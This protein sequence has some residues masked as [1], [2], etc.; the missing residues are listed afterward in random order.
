MANST[1][2]D[3]DISA[4]VNLAAAKL[5]YPVVQN[6]HCAVLKAF[7]KG[8][9]VFVSLSTDFDKS[10]CYSVLPDVFDTLH[11]VR[12]DTPKST[13]LVVSPNIALMKDQVRLLERRGVKAVFYGEADEDTR[14]C[15]TEGRY[16]L[17]FMT[18]ESLLTDEEWEDT[19]SC[20][21]YQEHLIGVAV[22]QTHC[23][24]KW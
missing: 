2:R 21:H 13:A 18:P 15:I 7:L 9:D 22:D 6:E 12:G 10:L 8:S 17:V 1:L 20:S 3:K 16:Q 5:G 4:A 23:V 24:K 19:L 11:G 14:G